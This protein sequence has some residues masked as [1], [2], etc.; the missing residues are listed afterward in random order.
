VIGVTG[1]GKSTSVDLLTGLLTPTQGQSF[2]DDLDLHDPI[3]R[4]R[5]LSRRSSIAHVPQVIHL[6]N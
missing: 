4:E 5:L 1:S 6:A 3:C 2:L